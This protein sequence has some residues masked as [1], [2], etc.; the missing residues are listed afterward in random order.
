MEATT[1]TRAR[2]GYLATPLSLDEQR[3]VGWMYRK[4]QGLIRLL[5][6]R[7]CR[8]YR[9]V[10][11][12]DIFSSIDIAFIKAC[13]AWDA[14]RGAFSTVL[15]AFCQG[16]VLHYIRDGNWMIKA[17]GNVRRLGQLARRML[18]Q[19]HNVCEVR[20]RLGMSEEQLRNALVATQPAEHDIRG[21]DLQE[22]SFA[23]PWEALEAEA[24]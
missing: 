16:E 13:R 9:F 6:R 7:M 24:I 5:G 12:D 10:S 17:P 19:G 11:A 21:F 14:E 22:S 2:T 18:E 4:H 1:R 23:T 15:T 3:Y 8:K 20:Q